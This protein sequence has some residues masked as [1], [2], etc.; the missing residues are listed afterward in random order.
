MNEAAS[1]GPN[2]PDAG[3]GA[4]AYFDQ[5]VWRRLAAAEAADAFAYSW[6][7]LQSRILGGAVGGVVL[8]RRDDGGPL[9]PVASW[10]RDYRATPGLVAAVERAA[11]ERKGVA[12]REGAGED[13]NPAT[14]PGFDL[15]YPVAIGDEVHAVA[16]FE[17][18]PRPQPEL[19]VAMRHLQW[20]VA[21]LQNWALRQTHDPGAMER[22][23]I[24]AALE[25]SASALEQERFKAA[26]TV[27]VTELA[28]RLDCDRVS[29]GVA[30][31]L[32]QVKVRALSHSA[33]FGK[34]M[35][36][37][38]SIALAME[39]SI[40]QAA[41]LRHPDPES[42]GR[43][44]TQAHQQL[45]RDHGSAAVL[46]VPL[47]GQDGGIFGALTFERSVSESFDAATVA[48]CESVAALLGPI[49]EAKRTIDRPLPARMW[50]TARSLAA[51]LFG[52]RHLV[53]KIA[54]AAVTVLA[55]A[56]ALVDGDF[57]VTAKTT[58]EGEIRRAVAAPFRGF[59]YE[60]PVR[61][62]DIVGEGQ[63][64]CSLDVRDL[65]LERSRWAS[66]REQYV[67]EHRKAM[68]ERER[69]AV[70]VLGKK[71]RQAEA[72]IALLDERIERA[73]MRAPFDGIVVTGD[74]S[75]SLGAPVETGQVLFEVAPLDQYRVTMRVDERDIDEIREGQQGSLVLTSLPTE[76]LTFEVVRIT[77]VSV[78][79]E[80]RN[81]FVVEG[82]LGQVSERLRP[83]ME[84]YGKIEVDRRK[85]LWI[86]THD[87]IDWVRI[88]LWRWLP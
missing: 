48:L 10:P 73:T 66:E 71:M 37:I 70:N 77:P 74:L 35:N 80:G 32:R 43:R 67:V 40:E 13:P 33:E 78:S 55:V 84:G 17:I 25:L 9:A 41:V 4:D 20:G 72:Q 69:A 47:R 65:R 51:K 24:R 11:A 79:E 38:R 36:L 21:W 57:R 27:V 8:F 26:A 75:Q 58:L 56:L 61:S 12:T 5:A 28:T 2:A 15:A 31:V 63:V 52:P 16:A 46:T 45:A 49:L 50:D 23:R 34:Q 88:R 54:A 86:W 1:R 44:V 68:A 85:L 18:R 53:W 7:I 30:G 59:V 76:S 29:L 87:M 81:L 39:E 64:M 22:A 19:H 83:G 3:P 62:G 14:E 82:A 60:A 42:S 6:L